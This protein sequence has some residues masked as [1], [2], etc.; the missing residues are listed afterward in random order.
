MQIQE[1]FLFE[2]KMG[3]KATETTRNINNTFGP[4][5]ANKCTCSGGSRSFA[6]ETRALKMKS[7]R[8]L[9][10]TTAIIKTYSLTITQEV[11]E[12]LN[13]N[14]ST[15]VQHLKQTGKVKKLTKWVSHELSKNLKT[16]HFELSSYL[17]HYTTMK[18]HF[19]MGL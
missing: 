16:H 14:H 17:L 12:E 13:I 10:I 8:K 6:N 9:T 18:N 1:I 2:F 15:A 19:S 5:T 11:A 3:Y 7:S 4:E